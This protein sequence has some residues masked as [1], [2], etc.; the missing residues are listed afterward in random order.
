MSQTVPETLKV[1]LDIG[2][3]LMRKGPEGPFQVSCQ[4]SGYVL[5]D[6]GYVHVRQQPLS[7][8]LASHKQELR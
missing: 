7:A 4:I 2:V 5:P 3:S 6:H 1:S 8:L